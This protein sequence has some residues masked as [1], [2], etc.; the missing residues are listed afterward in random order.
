MKNKVNIDVPDAILEQL[1]DSVFESTNYG[2]PEIQRVGPKVRATTGESKVQ[3]SIDDVLS[4]TLKDGMTISFH[5]HFR[6]GDFVFNKV[7]RKIIDMGYQ[8]LTLAPSSLTNV[9]ND[10]VIEAI[11]KGVVTNITSSGM[12]GT[13]GDAV[14]HGILKNP[15]IFRSH[16]ARARAIESGEIKIDVAFLGVPNSDEMGNANGMN[17]DAAFGS[18]GYA[19]IDAQYA[20]K[21]V[22]ITDTIMPYPN[23]PASI[24]QTQVDYVVKVDK[25]G[26]PDKIGSGA[27]R[28][29][30]D[31]KELKIAKTVNDVIVNS[32]YF[33]NDFSFQTGS[34]G[35]ALAVTRFLRE[36]MMAQNIMA[37]FALGGITKPTVDLLNEGLVNRVMDVQDFDK[38]A[39]S[40]MKL[41]P[42]QQEIDASWYA[43][44]ANKGAMVDK[45]D[46]AILS[47]LE[48]DTNFNVNVMS[49]SDGVIRGAIG[50]HQDAATAKL[51]II[52]VPLV[53]GRI[54]T[55]VPK[56]NT[57]ITPGDSIDVVVTEV[58][59]AINPKRTDL[60]EQLK[61]VPGL[62]I[63]SIEELQQKAEKIVGQPA[64][65]KFTDRVVAVA[66]YRDGS[67]IDIIKEVAD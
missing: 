40:S 57:V 35:A 24:K 59:I 20:D 26:D 48:V 34:G 30:K 31:P 16:G 8:N 5:H 2:N 22:L 53:R 36:A 63:Y 21:L 25:V 46:V 14:S 7:M 13:L 12:R 29:T 44:P 6:E 28:F 49:G 41:S 58:G 42:N 39:A 61:Q 17:G 18:L 19:L 51:T 45:L 50:G 55:I 54:A 11:K 66:E 9:M 52:S 4:N 32:K 27:T 65:L 23:T 64:P 62:P 3:S 67:V 33:K 60:V 15:V 37:S 1:D 47:A 43:D 38:G 10:I 56:V